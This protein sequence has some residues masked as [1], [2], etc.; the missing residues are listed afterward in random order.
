MNELQ[1]KVI[2]M[3]A[4]KIGLDKFQEYSNGNKLAFRELEK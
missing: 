3:D 2:L 4:D 1:S